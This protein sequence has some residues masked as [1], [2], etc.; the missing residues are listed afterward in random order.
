VLSVALFCGLTLG[1]MPARATVS[2]QGDATSVQ[3]IADQATVSEVLNAIS[4]TLGLRY[5]TKANLDSLIGGTYRGSLDNV[6]W[7]I[8]RGYNFVIKRHDAAF[9]LLVVGKAGNFSVT[10]G[11][12]SV[13]VTPVH[14]AIPQSFDLEIRESRR[15]RW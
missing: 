6:L 5:D 2:V 4:S 12:S 13:K 9:Y 8:L 11:A 15:N 10:S 3:V 1:A 14:S 7:R